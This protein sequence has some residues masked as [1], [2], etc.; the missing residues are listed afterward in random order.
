M[1]L[2]TV[3]FWSLIG[4]V[5]SLA[6]GGLL[7]TKASLRKKLLVYAVPFGAGALLATAFTNTLPEALESGL[8]PHIALRYAL[9]GFLAFFI[10]ERLAGWLHGH[11]EH[12][13]GQGR[14]QTQGVMVIVG[15][16]LHNA[17]DGVA[18][19]VAFLVDVPTGIVT[20][21]AVAA[22]ELPQ[23]IGDFGILLSRGFT[24]KKVLLIN[25]LSGLA[26][27][28]AALL[29]FT[30]GQSQGWDLGYALALAAGFFIYIAASDIIPEIHESP[31][32]LANI[33]ATILLVGVLVLVGIGSLLPHGH[34]DEE[35]H[36]ED[37]SQ[38][39]E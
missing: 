7:L 24:P 31:R 11:H 35:T 15:D 19:G 37:V 32:R 38:H 4:G 29:T 33:Q 10:L 3:L 27:V 5:V 12:D 9:I 39:E 18:I 1:E 14:K 34:T 16:T 17:I 30:L 28:V 25:V 13:H 2:L 20:S 22:H 8:D 21:M 23:E 26:T 6:F 36:H